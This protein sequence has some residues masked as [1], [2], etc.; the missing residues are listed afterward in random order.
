VRTAALS[1]LFLGASALGQ[2]VHER[3]ERYAD[4]PARPAGETGRGY[5]PRG[6]LAQVNVGANGA[7]IIGD[8]GNEPSMAVDPTAPNR[9]AVGW[10]QFDNIASNFRQAGRAYSRDGGR[11]WTNPGVLD[12]GVFR[13]DPCLRADNQGSIYYCSINGNFETSIFRSVDGGASYGSPAAAF[14]GDKEWLAIDRT[15]LA[16]SGNLYQHYSTAFTRSFDS[17]LT[18]S[19]PGGTVPNWGV[20]TVGPNGT[21]YIGGAPGAGSTAGIRVARSSNASNPLVTPTFTTAAVNLGGGQSSF[22]TTSPNP[23]GLLGQ[24]WVDTDRSTGPRAGWVYVLCSI[25]P[26]GTDPLD[27][28]FNRSTDGGATWLATPIRVNPDPPAA[29]SFQWFGTMSVAPN[30]RIDVVYNS[31]HESLNPQ[32]SRTYT[33][34]S[35]DGGTTWS[36]PVALTPQWDSWA[37]W[38]NQ[39]KIGDY[40]DM[41]SDLVG[42]DL[43]FAATLNGGQDVFYARIGP[44]DCNRNGIDDAADIAAGAADCNA[45]G[46]PD[47][48]EVAANADLDRNHNGVLDACEG[49]CSADFNGDGDAGTDADIEAFF[50]CLAGHCCPRCGSADFNGDGDVGTDADIESFFRVLGGGAC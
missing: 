10:R 28:M 13:S 47:S 30:G 20:N 16:S 23:G 42:A 41:S 46:I 44:R 9:I 25:D 14:G 35:G 40:Y 15:T 32:L 50:A 1:C 39:N 8:A 24:V 11:T 6:G 31:T 5:A 43:V 12:P 17:G 19:T 27:V 2:Q 49:A 21:V 29:N 45:N 33:T 34:S 22:V 37:G 48:C 38:P 3:S 18:W 7:D 36:T 4:P 26:L